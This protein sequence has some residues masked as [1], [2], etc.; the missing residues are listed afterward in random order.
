MLITLVLIGYISFDCSYWSHFF[1]SLFHDGCACSDYSH[2]SCLLSD[3]ADGGVLLALIM[4]VLITPV[5][6]ACSDY[7]HWS[8]LISLFTMIM[9]VLITRIDHACSDYS[10]W[11][12]LLGLLALITLVRITRIAHP[13]SNYSHWSLFIWLLALIALVLVTSIDR[14]CCQILLIR[15]ITRVD[16]ACSDYSHWWRLFWLP[17]LIVLV[18]RSCGWG[19]LL[20]LIML[21]L[22]TH[23]DH[24]F[25]DYSHW[26]CL[27]LDPADGWHGRVLHPPLQRRHLQP[28]VRKEGE[29]L[30]NIYNF[31]VSLITKS[32]V[33]CSLYFR[34]LF[35]SCV[36]QHGNKNVKKRETITKTQSKILPPT[37][38][39]M[40]NFVVASK[41]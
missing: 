29:K 24:A 12:R 31:L 30:K 7:S 22:I 34:T 21:V 33:F 18:V 37:I 10:H 25:S 23:T 8:C 26:S 11:S 16:P 2:W 14:A 5:D 13:C 40:E 4:L 15:G 41:L 39:A 19:V 6:H 27:F 32:Q 38:F 17:A 20:A 28:R 1:L 3:P 36:S 35:Y 9:L